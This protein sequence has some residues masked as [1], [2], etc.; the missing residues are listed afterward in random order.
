[1]TSMT[2]VPAADIT[3]LKGALMK[4][5]AVRTLGKVPT[6]LGVYWHNPKVLMSTFG[7]ATLLRPFS[8]S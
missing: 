8:P 1:M 5:M 3:G 2:R 7:I 6:A 4:R